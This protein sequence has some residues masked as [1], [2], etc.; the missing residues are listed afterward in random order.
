MTE[1]ITNA[2]KYAFPEPKSGTIQVSARRAD[3]T[4]VKLSIRDDGVGMSS[5][6]REGS[7]GYGIVRQLVAQIDGEI[8]VQ[9]EAGVTVTVIFPV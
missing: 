8:T 4:Q 7:L 9:A 3:P 2:V 6:S 5:G 1:L